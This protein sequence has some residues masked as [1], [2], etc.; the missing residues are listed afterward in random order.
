MDMV[1]G[2]LIK[3]EAFNCVHARP[4]ANGRKFKRK[5]RPGPVAAYLLLVKMK[6]LRVVCVC[7]C[8]AGMVWT[9]CGMMMAGRVEYDLLGICLE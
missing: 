4:S 7:V 3:S 8:M 1:Y 5:G 2:N 9:A 6:K